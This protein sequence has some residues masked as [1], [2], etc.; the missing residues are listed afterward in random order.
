[1]RRLVALAGLLLAA[2]ACASPPESEPPF[3]GSQP[4]PADAAP[5]P[6]SPE[7]PAPA[8]TS[9]PPK[10]ACGAAAVQNLVG[11][12]RTDIPVPTDPDRQRVACTTC[13]VTEDYRPERLNF[14][15]DAGTGRIR[16][17]R[18]G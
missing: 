2:T 4:P 7:P 18:C 11:R 5:P 3:P 1:M 13:P 12:P 17:I 16:E 9:S 10:D 6:A 14:F 8:P 15:F